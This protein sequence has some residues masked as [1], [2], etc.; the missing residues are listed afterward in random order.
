MNYDEETLLYEAKFG[1]LLKELLRRLWHGGWRAWYLVSNFVLE[2]PKRLRC[3]LIGHRLGRIIKVPRSK[4][5]Y[6]PF[7]DEEKV[8]SYELS[9]PGYAYRKCA[10]CGYSEDADAKE[11]TKANR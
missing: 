5:I 11:T 2:T 8:A 4:P 3:R 1:Q 9:Y 10:R 7:W 6:V